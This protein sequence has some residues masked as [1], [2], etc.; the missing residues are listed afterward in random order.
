MVKAA[1]YQQNEVITA[2]RV[3]LVVML[4]E[5]AINFLETAKQKLIS[6]DMAGKGVYLTKATAIVSELLC[7]L[8]MEAGGEIARNLHRLYDF[9]LR[10]ITEASVR[11]ETEP[12]D[13]TISILKELKKGW[14]EISRQG[15][16]MPSQT[17][18]KEASAR[19]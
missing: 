14:E 11:N 1:N 5:G 10:Q 3:K 17:R 15:V 9:M 13:T 7:S 8:D 12:I 2:N 16:A 18:I 4:Y 6:G 19:V